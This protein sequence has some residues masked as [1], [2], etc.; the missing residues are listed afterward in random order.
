MYNRKTPRFIE[1]QEVR[2]NS[3][4]LEIRTPLSKIPLLDEILFKMCKNEQHNGYVLIGRRQVHVRNAS[5]KTKN[6]VQCLR[7]LQKKQKKNS[8]QQ[9]TPSISKEINYST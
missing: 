9:E 8:K 2:G 5:E 4:Q 7:A 6:Y 3:N 1:K